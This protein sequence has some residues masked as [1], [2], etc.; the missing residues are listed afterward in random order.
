MPDG[1]RL[2]RE[3]P[4]RI[5]AHFLDN[6]W[7]IFWCIEHGFHFLGTATPV[8]CQVDF[9]LLKCGGLFFFY[10][11]DEGDLLLVDRALDLK[12]ILSRL[13]PNDMTLWT[14]LPLT[15][16]RCDVTASKPPFRFQALWRWERRELGKDRWQEF[17]ARGG[18][19]SNT[20]WKGEK[21][22]SSK[23]VILI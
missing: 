10:D 22:F 19:L 8:L 11:V 13:G 17:E 2:L 1:W 7:T 21:I 14:D 12:A 16:L 20:W 6:V 3:A 23:Q 18:G 4:S 5:W 9:V 15:K